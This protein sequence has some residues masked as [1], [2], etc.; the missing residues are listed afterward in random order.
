MRIYF[1]L[2]LFFAVSST[3]VGQEGDYDDEHI[4]SSLSNFSSF[5]INPEFYQFNGDERAIYLVANGKIEFGSSDYINVEFIGANYTKDG[6]RGYTF[7]DFSL[8]YTKN[9]YSSKF[10]NRGFQG[11]SP[12][13]KAIIP[14]G[15][16]EYSAI[17]GYWIAEPSI[18]YSW[19]LN[20][21]KFFISNRWR[22]FL[23]LI[24]AKESSE[25]PLFIR[26][27]PRFGYE[28][29]KIWT[30][31]TLDNRLIINQ[32]KFVLFYRLDGGYKI[33]ENSGISFFYTER[34][35]NNVLFRRYAGLSYYY[36]F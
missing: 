21:E 7:G 6:N 3:C 13:F 19:L 36:I 18:Y 33:N 8:A 24:E 23:P 17:F 2:L 35:Y 29:K 28:N 27:E 32:E 1:L 30:S 9:F 25:P 16:P 15:N 14:S 20:N 11:I 26:F 34:I 31:I 22:A 5:N 4:E 12:T 10:L